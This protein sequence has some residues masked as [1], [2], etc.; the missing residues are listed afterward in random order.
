MRR[1]RG[2]QNFFLRGRQRVWREKMCEKLAEGWRSGEKMI[3]ECHREIKTL[4]F[5]KIATNKKQHLS[6]STFPSLFTKEWANSSTYRE[7]EETDRGSRRTTRN[8]E[9]KKKKQRTTE[10]VK[11]GTKGKMG[12]CPLRLRRD[13]GPSPPRAPSMGPLPPPELVFHGHPNLS[14]SLLCAASAV[15][16]PCAVLQIVSSI[17]IKWVN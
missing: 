9:Q 4:L 11:Q 13:G 3:W 2:G 7:G 10:K 5:I 6:S 15:S 8:R 17:Q 14:L 1:R 12:C 16:P